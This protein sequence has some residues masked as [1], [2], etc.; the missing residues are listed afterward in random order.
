MLAGE[1]FV[2][3]KHLLNDLIGLG[4]WSEEM[5][6][7]LIAERGS[8]QNIQEIP[9]E[10]RDVYKTVWE[11]KKSTQIIMAQERGNYICQS[12]SF[13]AHL[14]NP[15]VKELARWDFMTWKKGLKTG[16]YYLRTRPAVEAIQF[17]VDKKVIDKAKAGNENGN[18]AV[19]S[20]SSFFG[21]STTESS[22]CSMEEG[23]LTCGS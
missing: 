14:Q 17:T 10:I 18:A 8:V 5:R 20:S 19:N 11:I 4:L 21:E 12:Q 16:Q 1:F 6:Q 3:N 13:N 23:C 2:V 22:A 9:K 15:S 7:R